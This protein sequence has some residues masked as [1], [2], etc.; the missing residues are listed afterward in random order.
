MIWRVLTTDGFEVGR[1]TQENNV[2][3]GSL[4][5]PWGDVVETIV[6]EALVGI[7]RIIGFGN[8]GKS[9]S[10][11]SME[12]KSILTPNLKQIPGRAPPP[13]K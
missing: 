4:D 2:P 12:N 8:F 13:P 10:V 7:E 6:E 9:S 11:K 5:G 3:I 1:A